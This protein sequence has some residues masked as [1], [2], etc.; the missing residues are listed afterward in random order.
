M[1][2]RRS[3]AEIRYRASQESW[4][5]KAFLFPPRPAAPV[6][7]FTRLFPSPESLAGFLAGVPAY[8]SRILTEAKR[9]ADG[10]VPLLGTSVPF[11]SANASSDW[12]RDL[13][14][15]QVTG[16]DYFRRI[17]YLDAARAG[18]HKVIW[19]LNRHQHLVLLA[20][21]SLLDPGEPR[22]ISVIAE[23]VDCWFAANPFHRGINWASALEVAF[24]A[25]SWIWILHLAG[26]RLPASCRA[27]LLHGL[28]QHG[29]HLAHN[30]SIYFAPNTHLLGEAVC[31]H[32]LGC[33]FPQLP[34]SAHWRALGSE[35][36]RRSLETQVLSDGAYFEQSTYY[37]LYAVDLFLFH[38]A[39]NPVSKEY[40][41]RLRDMCVLLAGLTDT[42]GSFPLIGD[43]D[44]G[45]FFH[46]YGERRLFPR[47]T[48]TT[49]S[50]FF[51]EPS[52]RF[53]P[54]DYAE[55]G[56]WLLGPQLPDR[57]PAMR[58]AVRHT[59]IFRE[60]GF[61]CAGDE[62]VHLVLA[63]K[64]FGTGSA[65]HSHAHALHF[66][67]RHDGQDLLIDSGT[68]TY[69]GDLALRERF[70]GTAAHNTVRI[71][72]LNQS[73]AVNPF[74][75][76]PERWSGSLPAESGNVSQ[77]GRLDVTAVAKSHDGT[78]CV[79]RTLRW[80]T[81]G[82][83]ICEDTL[84]GQGQHAIEQF[85][86]VPVDAQWDPSARLLRWARGACLKPP[87]G[88]EAEF[89]VSEFS[90]ALGHRAPAGTLRLTL[91]SSLPVTL[92]AVIEF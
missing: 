91:R 35:W 58:P 76:G 8:K 64:A 71:D 63:A 78:I 51:D 82:A 9:I 86:H 69:V 14:N 79:T 19:E 87:E 6:S 67:L 88:T 70:R 28:Y 59:G 23:Q 1:R 25:L 20:E 77:P 10:R 22:W 84:A 75:W 43:D 11:S 60:S 29:H 26:D 85:W 90:G 80:S 30:L 50:F 68:F 61:V 46:P 42:D 49:A 53:Q 15:G 48:L 37:H 34:E 44:G 74:R 3:P 4:N 38:A 41:D 27:R 66:V 89:T 47:A 81:G 17:P 52:W 45:R 57:F 16:T 56:L 72:G 39:L 54:E 2:W 33:M 21:A 83:L 12:R 65:G 7:S 32:A 5:L 40:L 31:L 36:V 73:T 55:T 24:R 62:R 18:D 92:R 13:V